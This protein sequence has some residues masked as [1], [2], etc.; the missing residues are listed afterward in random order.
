MV[1]MVAIGIFKNSV[2]NCIERT[3]KMSKNFSS[4]KSKSNHKV[5]PKI[6]VFN[7]IIHLKNSKYN[8]GAVRKPAVLKKN[9]S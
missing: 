6:L 8:V 2:N 1:C 9:N 7:P 4:K 3:I 5:I